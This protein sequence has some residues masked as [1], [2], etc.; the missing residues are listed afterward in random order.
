MLQ[1]NSIVR[2]FRR[3]TGGLS[4]LLCLEAPLLADDFVWE[5]PPLSTNWD[6]AVNWAGPLGQF[7]NGDQDTATVDGTNDLDPILT[8]DRV[9]GELTI[10]GTADVHTGDGV[11][12]YFLGV[13]NTGPH[14]GT[15]SIDG[16]GS[17]LVVY[18]QFGFDVDT[19]ILNTTNGGRVTLVG[20]GDVRVDALMNNSGLIRGNGLVELGGSSVSTNDGRLIAD[21]G[22]LTLN[23][24]GT[25]SLD[26][27]GAFGD[28][29][30]EANLNASLI[31]NTPLSDANFDGTMS[32]ASGGEIQIN[33]PWTLND[34]A[35]TRLRFLGG[36]DPQILS[37]SAIAVLDNEVEVFAGTAQLAAPIVF[38]SNAQVELH[39]GATLQFDGQ[40]TALNPNALDLQAS[41]TALVINNLVQIGTGT[42]NF[43]WDGGGQ[44]TTT[45]N[46]DAQ[47]TI[48]VTTADAV[49][50][51][52]DGQ[53]NMNS[54]D[55]QVSTDAGEWEMAGTLVMDRPGADTPAIS[56]DTVVMSG[57]LFSLGTH[58]Q[59]LA[60]SVF[61]S[62]SQVHVPDGLLI[63]D[64]ASTVIEGGSW[65]GDGRVILNADS[66]RVDQTTTVNMPGGRFDLDGTSNHALTLN[67]PLN[68]NVAEV[69]APG[70]AY[71]GTLTINPDG[72]LDLDLQ[73]PNEQ[74]TIN[75]DVALNG[76]G[77]G[78]TSLH[79]AGSTAVN[80]NGTT[81]VTGS[82]T[83]QSRVQLNGNV[84][85]EAFS[86]LTLQGGSTE[87]RNRLGSSA[88]V[89]GDG[90]LRVATS[91][92]LEIS[93][94][95][96]VNVNVENRG[97]LDPGL[98]GTGVV[99]LNGNYV[100]QPSGTLGFDIAD[101]SGADQDWL[102]ATGTMTLNGELNVSTLGSFVP[103]PGDTYT[104]ATAAVRLGT[105]DTLSFEL[106]NAVDVNGSLSY[107]AT[108]VFL[109]ID[110]VSLS[111]DF[112]G[113]FMLDCT[114]IDALVAELASGGM[115][116]QFD[117]NGDATVDGQDL[118]Q[119]L[120]DAG[121]LNVGAAYLYGDANLDGVVDGQD[122]V[123]W[124]ANKFTATPAWCQGDFN[125]DGLVDGQDFIIWNS[126]KFMGADLA[127]TALIVPEPHGRN[128]TLLSIAVLGVLRRRH[129]VA[130]TR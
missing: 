81:T 15:I 78:F 115:D 122:F 68:L 57:Q 43:N 72:R 16:A 75:G 50:N 130:C 71:T 84:H 18:E 28:G 114:D 11:N 22:S 116:L 73:N 86:G 44:T 45:I 67:A 93:D 55:L 110:S 14:T 34:S 70:S 106:P 27:D 107:G 100:Q 95:A 77:G 99:L 87:L 25:A 91:G 20:G 52:F 37:G 32:I 92:Q 111:G 26:L 105:F 2:I 31:I 117:L 126:N 5:S 119:W 112:D 121:E 109:H 113:D 17:Q 74:F 35:G 58:A 49:G 76:A 66:T 94:S 33:D 88:T 53:L 47:L 42:G 102:Q 90:L 4:L 51:R 103:V 12:N 61:E 124:N 29:M 120:T 96:S 23:A 39:E 59:I 9:V 69:D 60:S 64:G 118:D 104:V 127:A 19:D 65:T 123:A 56:G 7:P 46:Q 108:S 40:A 98:D 101:V 128:L 129:R 97:R 62:S 13:A 30:L 24:T 10:T 6:S 54:G 3:L 83:L 41:Q 63:L 38:G 8:Q 85:L 79:L 36:P 21:G 125:A 82:S 48:S 1:R 80:L 89:T